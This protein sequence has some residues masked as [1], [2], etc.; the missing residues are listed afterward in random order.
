MDRT[1]EVKVN[2]SHLTK[3]NKAAGV[4]YE[5]NA[6]S[7]R[8][9]F[10]EGWD[11]YAKKVTWWDAKGQ[12]PTKRNLTADLLEDI[13]K[14]TRIY[15]C[16][17]PGEAMTAAGWCTFVIDGKRH[18]SLS[19]KLEVKPAPYNEDAGEP[20]DPTPTQAQQLQAQIDAMLGDIA[21]DRIAAQEAATDAE[22]SAKNASASEKNA[23]SHANIASTS[24]ENA[25]KDAQNAEESARQVQQWADRARAEV[26]SVAEPMA[27]GIHNVILTDRMTGTKYALLVEDGALTV[28][29]VA[30][31]M[32]ATEMCLIDTQTGIGYEVVVDDGRIA[33]KEV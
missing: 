28:L 13:T 22:E 8:I 3:D 6:K 2:G 20:A 11:G 29:Q 25:R 19:D 17:I 21:E 9:I 14:S 33:I 30:D 10:D 26:I 12:N 16:P 1:I 15:L 27:S 7:L 31:T 23:F 5:S 24:A 32:E 4:Q 18:R